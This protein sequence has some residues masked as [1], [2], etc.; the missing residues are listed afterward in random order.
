M[1]ICK[2]LAALT[3]SMLLTGTPGYSNSA[4]NPYIESGTE[5]LDIG[6]Y[7]GA[8]KDFN[9]VVELSPNLAIAYFKRG[10]ARS[11]LQMYSEA[12]SDFNKAI[13]INPNYWQSYNNRGIAKANAGN[14]SQQSLEAA[15]DDY[16]RSIAINPENAYAHTNGGFAIVRKG[17]CLSNRC[18]HVR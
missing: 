12:I 4:V 3:L 8:L 18:R 17:N 7:K 13:D 6:D 16:N 11:Y 9:Q 15:I 14:H 5:K 10:T 1:P 2:S